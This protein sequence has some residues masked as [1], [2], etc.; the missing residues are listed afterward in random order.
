MDMKAHHWIAFLVVAVIAYYAG[1]NGWLRMIT[2][3]LPA[4]AGG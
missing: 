3:K 1:S 2:A 4:A